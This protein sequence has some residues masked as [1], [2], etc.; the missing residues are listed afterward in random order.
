MNDPDNVTIPI[1]SATSNNAE[2]KKP[3]TPLTKRRPP[4]SRFLVT[5]FYMGLFALCA[6]G[7]WL[8]LAPASRI[9]NPDA[10]ADFDRFLS[11]PAFSFVPK[12]SDEP[13]A[14]KKEDDSTSTVAIAPPLV[15]DV[16]DM[17]SPASNVW[18]TGTIEDSEANSK[19]ENSL[20]ISGT[21]N[22]PSTVR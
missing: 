18:F 20:R 5:S 7:G 19:S 9:D 10:V 11:A 22:D 12:P 13:T 14:D 1:H 8:C 6:W 2:G 15:G 16:T 4:V 17:T 21:P 3:E